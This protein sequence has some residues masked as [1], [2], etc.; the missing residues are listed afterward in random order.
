MAKRKQPLL[1]IPLVG[2]LLYFL[3]GVLWIR[4]SDGWILL[5]SEDVQ[6]LSLLQIY[7][8]WAFVSISAVL[9]GFLLR[10][11]QRFSD[12]LLTV[13][14]QFQATFEHAAAGI[15]HLNENGQFL[16]FNHEF[17]RLLQYDEK[18][19]V[20]VRFHD[21]THPDDLAHDE[22]QLHA[23]LV[24]DIDHYSL[25][26]RYIKRNGHVLWA[27]LSVALVPQRE[28]HPRYLIAVIQDIS[29][30]KEAELLLQASELRFRTL[31]DHTPS[32]SVQGYHPDGTT[33]FWNKA[34]ETMYGYSKQEAIGRNL[35]DLIIPPAMK[36]TVST[37]IQQMAS[38]GIAQAP[39]ELVLQRKD[40]TDIPVYSSHAIVQV[41]AQMAQIYCID[42]DLSEHYRQERQLNFLSCFDPLTH[43]A[44]RQHFTQ[45]LN[46]ALLMSQ[47]SQQSLTVIL[48]DLDHFKNINDS[49]GHPMGDVLLQHVAQ[50]LQLYSHNATLLA[51]LGGDEF[52]LMF[53]NL[54]NEQ[55]EIDIATALMSSLQA[56]FILPE[57]GP[58][59]VAASMGICAAPRHTDSAEGL[60]QGADAA[61]YKAKSSGRNTFT[62]YSQQLADHARQQLLLETRLRRA[63]DEQHLCC[64]FQPQI[65]FQTGKMHGA[66][67]LVRWIDPELGIIPPN[68]FIP[69]AEA[70]GLIH[71]IG[72]F[73]LEQACFIGQRW[74][75]QGLPD[76]RLAINVSS[77]QFSQ[78][79]FQTLVRDTLLKSNFP[80]PLLELEITES[81]LLGDEKSVIKTM[82]ALRAL[83][84]RMAIDDFGT[85][86]SSLAYLKRLPLDVLKIDKRFVDDLEFDED[87]Q[88]ISQAIIQLAKVMKL[89]VLAEGVESAAQWSILQS[90]GCDMY[91]GYYYSK[92]LPE[93][94]FVTLLASG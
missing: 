61:L 94:E 63:L 62:V 59:L 78:P 10:A 8:G 72:Q 85:G 13:E 6:Q 27:R 58:I 33:L 70:C 52:A 9:V 29:A 76:I 3:F 32:I 16:R 54:P 20:N 31:L 50:R 68:D 60:L 83:G 35:I 86:Y 93:H 22:Q 15:A 79:Q 87:D 81:A 11:Q 25:E 12:S 67:L 4:F 53:E 48:L 39:E 40:G 82:Q 2:T 30:H 1:L 84:V 74:R 42:I 64:Y 47:K 21:I 7:K 19:L 49:F 91:Q 5:I 17:A 92:P 45:E 14:H 75:Q 46:R 90:L 43:L 51:R 57:H 80:P 28:Q 89:S 44:N 71:R 65:D 26:K 34:S 77:Q 23:L 69:L 24:G 56:P 88:Q 66:E 36:D 18:T 55:A 37:V 38:T 73:V 41:P